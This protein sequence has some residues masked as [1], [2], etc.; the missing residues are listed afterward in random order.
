MVSLPDGRSA[1]RV[2]GLA[3]H[4]RHLHAGGYTDPQILDENHG[5][6]TFTFDDGHYAVE[7]RAPDLAGGN[8]PE[9]PTLWTDEGT[10]IVSGGQLT[11]SFPHHGPPAVYAFT[12]AADGDLTWTLVTSTNGSLPLTFTSHPWNRIGDA[13]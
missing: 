9:D 11:I 10:Y 6:F 8:H 2:E 4:S 7:Q 1:P 3:R 12:Q 13:P 5:S